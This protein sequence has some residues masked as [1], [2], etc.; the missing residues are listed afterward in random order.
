MRYLYWIFCCLEMVSLTAQD[1][2]PTFSIPQGTPWSITYS[3]A[4]PLPSNTSI[5]WCYQLDTLYVLDSTTLET[6]YSAQATVLVTLPFL[7]VEHPLDLNLGVRLLQTLD[8]TPDSIVFLPIQLLQD[9]SVRDSLSLNFS[10][11]G[12]QATNHFWNTAAYYKLSLQQQW[13]H[14]SLDHWTQSYNR[15]NALLTKTTEKLEEIQAQ[16]KSYET[17][18]LAE[19]ATIQA[20]VDTVRLLQSNMDQLFA[21]LQAGK[22][23]TQADQKKIAEYTTRRNETQIIYRKNS[24]EAA[25]NALDQ[26]LFHQPAINQIQKQLNILQDNATQQQRKIAE[27]TALERQTHTN[28]LR[29]KKRLRSSLED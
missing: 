9:S 28:W 18:F 2:H 8:E 16:T 7:S 4:V 14:D 27:F 20:L 15:T 26:W 21:L 23:L 19:P 13:V 11:G 24:S 17:L 5:T 29:Y 1:T 3:T 22:T 10:N 6:A 12:W 25:Q